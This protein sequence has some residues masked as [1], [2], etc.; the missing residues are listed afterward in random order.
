M[1]ASTPIKLLTAALNH[2]GH[3]NSPLDRELRGAE[4][5]PLPFTRAGWGR[6]RLFG[7]AFGQMMA[8][9]CA[10]WNGPPRAAGGGDRSA[11]QSEDGEITPPTVTLCDSENL[12]LRASHRRPLPAR[13]AGL[14]SERRHRSST[15]AWR[16]RLCIAYCLPPAHRTVSQQPTTAGGTNRLGSI[17]A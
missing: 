2:R 4:R 8:T 9:R 3:V 6:R 14:P 17:S 11:W 7:A 10:R 12:E 13:V 5:T 16:L 1:V 15:P